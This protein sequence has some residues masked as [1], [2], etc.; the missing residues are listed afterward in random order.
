MDI[1]G[2]SM[3]TSQFKLAQ[4]VSVAVAKIAMDTA[5][6]QTNEMVKALEQ[7]VQPGKGTSIDIKV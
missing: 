1:A 6:V 4:Q 2:Y 5:K 7:S 3:L